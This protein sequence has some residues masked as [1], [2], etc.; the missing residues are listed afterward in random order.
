VARDRVWFRQAVDDRKLP[1]IREMPL[2]EQG[3]R[4]PV[5]ESRN[6]KVDVLQ[7][8]VGPQ[9]QIL[10]LGDVVLELDMGKVGA[11]P[12]REFGRFGIGDRPDAERMAADIRSRQ[13]LLVDEN[14][15][16]HAPHQRHHCT[17]QQLSLRRRRSDHYQAALA[18]P[19]T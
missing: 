8:P 19:P 4:R 7:R 10:N 3:L 11:Y 17:T 6:K 1:A 16:C 13:A 9:Q 14:K 5:A 2:I 15:H 18:T 12:L